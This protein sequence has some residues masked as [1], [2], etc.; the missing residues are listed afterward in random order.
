MTFADA[1]KLIVPLVGALFIQRFLQRETRHY[2]RETKRLQLVK[3]F[4]DLHAL[5]RPFISHEFDARCQALL[6]ETQQFIESRPTEGRSVAMLV[7]WVLAFA[8]LFA[9]LNMWI[10]PPF[11]HFVI[12]GRPAPEYARW[13]LVVLKLALELEIWILFA[14]PFRFLFLKGIG[15]MK[16]LEHG[17]ERLGRTWHALRR[18]R[19]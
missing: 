18:Y 3:A 8:V 6:D 15:P 5:E 9:P 4:Y 10:V 17:F 12:P 1:A 11:V 19:F 2:D 14:I 7:S 13:S 16:G